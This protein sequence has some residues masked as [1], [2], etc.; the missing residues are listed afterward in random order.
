MPLNITQ[1]V[2]LVLILGTFG[3]FINYIIKQLGTTCSSDYTYNQTLKKC[4]PICDI[5]E[6]NDPQTGECKKNCNG[7][8]IDDDHEIIS[9]KCVLKCKGQMKR[10]GFECVDNITRVCDKAGGVCN[11]NQLCKPDG[12]CC[13]PNEHCVLDGV[14][15]ENK[16][17]EC[18]HQICN[19]TCCVDDTYTCAGDKCCKRDNVSKDKNG[20]EVCC[21]QMPCIDEDGNKICCDVGAGEI[22][23]NGKCVIGCPNPKEMDLYTCNGVPVQYPGNVDIACDSTEMCLHNCDTNQFSCVPKNTCWKNTTYTPALL[24][25]GSS[26]ILLGDSSVNVCSE[27][28]DGSGNLWIKN[29]GKTLY[30]TVKVESNLGSTQNCGEQSCL[31]KI[32]Q[33]SSTIVNF[34]TPSKVDVTT[35][36]GL[37][38]SSISCS[39]NLLDQTQLNQVCGNIDSDSNQYGRCCRDSSGN[40]TGQICNPGES[41]ING[42]CV[43]KSTY[44]GVGGTFDYEN[45]KCNCVSKDFA[46][47][48]CQYTKAVTCEGKGSPRPDGKCDPDY[49]ATVRTTTWGCPL[50]TPANTDSFCPTSDDPSRPYKYMYDDSNKD[51]VGY[52]FGDIGSGHLGSYG[53]CA[54]KAKCA[55]CVYPSSGIQV[56]FNEAFSLALKVLKKIQDASSGST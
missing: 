29:P 12:I 35:N 6:I 31:N 20:I 44:C 43:N 30:N 19:G 48:Q 37:C 1:I 7:K 33:D 18:P 45:K 52:C 53:L 42:V 27:N 25:N 41:C 50:G 55:N 9:G 34:Q 21:D 36:P 46:G 8:V 5:D 17:D 54:R 11:I 16:C 51:G 23:K 26:N 40:Y 39:Q 10:C 4:V 32:S 22:C 56:Q 24:N 47:N 15:G 14:T 3:F 28:I 38:Q 49:E 2:A 13:K